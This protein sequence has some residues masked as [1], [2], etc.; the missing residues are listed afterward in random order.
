MAAARV[1]QDYIKN[2]RA[3]LAQGNATE[4]THRPAL[5][6][7]LES[8]ADGIVATNEPKRIQCGAPD[9]IITT[10]AHTPE[11]QL[12]VGYVEAKDV[13]ID[14][15]Q[16]ERDSKRTNPSTANG[17][18]LKR[19]RNSLTN[20]LLTNYTEFRWYVD[21]EQRLT[22]H[23][24]TLES[25]GKLS[26]NTTDFSPIDRLL[27]EFLHRSPARIA[28]PA[29]LAQRMARLT[30]MIRSVIAEGFR[31]DQVSQYLKDL[32]EASQRVL[33]PDLTAEAFADM[34]AQTLAYGLFAARVNH[35]AGA[36]RRQ[37]AAHA[38]P[39]TNPFLQQLFSALTGPALDDEPFVS[40]V[41]DL[42]QLLGSA[43][44]E[45]ILS[46]F[47]KR[48][49][50]QD[51]V[52]HFYETFLAAY[53]PALRER[54]GVYYTPEPV[55]S[56]IVRSVDYLLRQRFDCP[57][58]LADHAMTTYE[59]ADSEG[60]T[61]RKRAPRVLVLD[62]A[63]GTG[64]FLY[65]VIDH[66]R[67]YYRHS[68]NAG[69]WNGYVKDHLLKRLFGFELLMA[70]YAMS[71]LKLGM[72]LAAADMPEEYRSDWSYEFDSGERLGV[73]LTNSLEQAER[74]AM[75]LFGPLRVMTEE[76]NAAS[77]IKR[78]LP[79][80]VVLG[81]PPYSGHSA[82]ASR[83]D[84]RQLAWI[85]KLIEEY[86]QVDGMSLAER[87]L[88]WLQ[89]D[90]VKFIRFGQWRIRQAGAGILA[91]ITNHSYLDNPTF[92]GMR[93]QL[94]LTFTHIYLLDLHGNAKKKER[95]PDG[96][97]DQ[98]VFDIQ[99]GVAIAIFVKE[100]GKNGPAVVRHAD[101]WGTRATKYQS[102]TSSDLSTTDW[103]TIEPSSPNY[104]FKPWNRELEAEY[105]RWPRINEIMPVN[106]V[107]VVTAR[108]GLTIRWS[109]AE[110]MEVVRDFARLPS[111]TARSRYNLGRD[112][113]DWKVDL[114]QDDINSSGMRPELATPIQYRP[115]DTRYTYYTG[116]DCG[117][118]CRPRPNVM[119]HML[120]G[121]NL[122]LLICRQ[123]SQ[124]GVGWSHCG[125]TH[126]IVESCAVSNKTKEINYLCPLYIYRSEQE[127]ASGLYSPG[128]RQPNLAPEFTRD[129]EQRLGLRFIADG[130][131]NLQET[132]GP[133][134]AFH[135]IYAAFHS[136]TYRQRYDQFLRADFP[137]VPLTGNVALFRALVGLGRQ[138]TQVHLLKSLRLDQTAVGFPVPG[139]NVIERGHPKYL[140]PGHS[141]PTQKAPLEQGR[142]YISK[143]DQKSGKRGQCFEGI[144]PEIWEFRIGGYQP[145]D[146]WLKDRRG[147]TLSFDDLNHY[148]RMVAALAETGRLT[149]EIDVAISDAGGL[150]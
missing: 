98:N 138:L 123:Q 99:Q 23:I 61:A 14:L 96:S 4:H 137:R 108:D 127:I 97:P 16:I 130:K 107:G 139:D 132:F 91:F 18:Q 9:F 36:F 33:V 41:D 76:A 28:S 133:E 45:A 140:P 117:F 62:P 110:T 22:A 143:D 38:I 7:L 64:T 44:M 47:G 58:G 48:A 2:L 67:E 27:W 125:V 55:V 105:Q 136:P 21:G 116:K 77:Q 134:D 66:I 32:H 65:A 6:A 148:R 93:Q 111:E 53:D 37:D 121:E 5:K 144:A 17:R 104:M 56:Y 3:N 146:K 59:Y 40:F 12:T 69:M 147:R 30:R 42:T 80:M 142:V 60:N 26:Q 11:N 71:H 88:K 100:A 25:D 39:P 103:K 57:A 141:L 118:I 102:L 46:D 83:K 31:Q 85:G 112:V 135:Y 101:L 74:R 113:R 63:C 120:A 114:A 72:Q 87:N 8:V 95:A 129:L 49:V 81:N 20:L 43:D 89:D 79:I 52:M 1:F 82:N 145:L 34:F 19:Y 90:Y 13:E 109:R 92:R 24:A 128:D 119:R 131:G 51:P 35:N 94:V 10:S 75:T 29:D 15:T 126:S 73:Y 115:F 86:K 150:L 84:D 70:P 68:D 106:S 149:K 122:G 54:R 50:Y 78:D 124:S